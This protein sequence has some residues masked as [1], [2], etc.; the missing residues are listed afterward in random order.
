MLGVDGDLQLGADAV[1]GGDQQRILEAGGLGVEKGAETAERGVRA[2]ARGG[3][4]QGRD[5]F[6]QGIAG[7]DVDARVLVSPVANGTPARG[8]CCG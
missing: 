6:D 7:I 8:S 1:G 4:G 2:R 3:A 5:G